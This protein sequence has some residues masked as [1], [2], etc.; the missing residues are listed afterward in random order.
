MEKHYLCDPCLKLDFQKILDLPLQVRLSE[1]GI[2]VEKFEQK[3]RFTKDKDCGICRLLS[4]LFLDIGA[5]NSENE[6]GSGKHGYELRAFNFL[7]HIPAL[8]VYSRSAPRDS[9]EYLS[10]L[11]LASS[12]DRSAGFLTAAAWSKAKFHGQII[13]FND[14][15]RGVLAKDVTFSGRLVPSKFDPLPITK[16]LQ[17]CKSNHTW[18]CNTTR[19]NVLDMELIDCYNLTVIPAPYGASY[20]ALSYV[21]G[22][23]ATATTRTN[24]HSLPTK[25]PASI[26]DA[27]TVT[28]ALGYRYLW[29][30][31]FCIDQQDAVNKHKQVQQMDI[32]YQQAELTII[33]ASGVDANHGLPGVSSRPRSTQPSIKVGKVQILSTLPL[34]QV[35]IQ[36]STW[37]SRGWTFQEAFLSRRRLIFLDDQ[38]Y[39][40]CEMTNAWE[41]I[42]YSFGHLHE[43]DQH[44]IRK[45]LR[46]GIFGGHDNPSSHIYKEPIELQQYERYM[47]LVMEYSSRELSYPEDSLNAFTGITKYFRSINPALVHLWGIPLLNSGINGISYWAES[48]L[49]ESL[50]FGL[51][52]EHMYSC[53]DTLHKPTRR[54]SF[55][56]WSWTGWH[57]AIQYVKN[58]V[59][60]YSRIKNV[61][62]KL[63]NGHLIDSTRFFSDVSIYDAHDCHPRVLE[64]IAGI[65]PPDAASLSN[66]GNV[67]WQIH[68]QFASLN[69][70]VGSLNCLDF[71][72]HWRAGHCEVLELGVK[73]FTRFL[74]VVK[75]HGNTASRIGLIAIPGYD[76]R[77]ESHNLKT[78]LFCLV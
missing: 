37:A 64:F 26:A 76:G 17:N 55:P 67:N 22:R 41:S 34:P 77:S 53:W 78:K 10:L 60:F 68:G 31:K 13:F 57:G 1:E 8:S 2:I 69:L 40:E 46:P 73:Q 20:V 35:S 71:I 56:S 65:I 9:C 36:S 32:I 27:I 50:V 7:S 43:S 75:W 29:V 42:M 6:D 48:S 28:K 59:A 54:E 52:W 39:I 72:E 14:S 23:N 38:V 4:T 58:R 62:F 18:I 16:W 12:W 24:R 70:S 33:C 49:E 44:L 45:D 66:D 19:S 5:Q 74:L 15:E 30:D 3:D 61:Q 63:E 51:T 11:V 47:N 21:W 25:L